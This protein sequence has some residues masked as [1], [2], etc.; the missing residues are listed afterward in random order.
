M[1]SFT[2][3][4]INRINYIIIK[5]IRTSMKKRNEI[6]ISQMHI[7]HWWIW[8]D[9]FS[10]GYFSTIR[11]KYT[12]TMAPWWTKSFEDDGTRWTKLRSADLRSNWQNN[13]TQFTLSDRRS[14][15][16][17]QISAT[18]DLITKT[19]GK[20]LFRSSSIGSIEFWAAQTN[21]GN[22]QPNWILR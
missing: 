22:L 8:K 18:F 5:V 10:S 16:R 3:S 13:G 6:V 12:V 11:R 9:Q 14:F 17:R 2:I 19:I 21:F 7:G 20:G 4:T 15:E 1:I